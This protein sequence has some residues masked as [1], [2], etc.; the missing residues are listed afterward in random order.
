MRTQGRVFWPLAFGL[1]LTDCGTKK[2]IE[3]TAPAVGVPRHII[4][5][6]VRFTLAYNQGAAFSIH[7]GPYQRWVLIGLTLASLALCAHWYSDVARRGRL[8]IVGLALV[9]GGAGGNLLDRLASHRGVIDFIDVGIGAARFY[10]FNVAD[11]GVSVG[12]ALLV[13]A[14]WRS[15]RV[16]SHTLRR[17]GRAI[18]DGLRASC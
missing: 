6:V 5:G 16:D 11:V 18:E 14:M 7:F 10:V 15:E 1:L 3:K 8:A 4:D 2:A 12:A 13:V 9:V 17:S